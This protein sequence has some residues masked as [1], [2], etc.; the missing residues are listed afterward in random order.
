MRQDEGVRVSIN[1]VLPKWFPLT[2]NKPL[3]DDGIGKRAC[4]LD[5]AVEYLWRLHA[6]AADTSGQWDFYRAVYWEVY[7]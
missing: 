2:L 3:P 7:E 1:L 4:Y 6:Y 5:S